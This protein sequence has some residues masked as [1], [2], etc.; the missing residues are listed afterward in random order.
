MQKAMS[1][2]SV[3]LVVFIGLEEQRAGV[4]K[5]EALF[6]DG[7]SDAE[8]GGNRVLALSLVAQGGEGAELVDRMKGF[9]LGVFG[10]AVGLDEASAA[11][12][13]GDRRV[14]GEL[15]LFD[16]HLQRAQAAS[17]RL[18]AVEAGLFAGVVRQEGERLRIAEGR[19]AR[20]RR[21]GF[22]SRRRP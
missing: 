3:S 9:A 12:D 13:A 2:S 22:R 19:G 14:L 4:R 11:D 17:A 5:P 20:C 6:D 16:E 1:C 8:G 10:E 15:L 7:G 21:Q 18:N